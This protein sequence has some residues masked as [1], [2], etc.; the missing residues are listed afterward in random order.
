VANTWVN[1]IDYS[2]ST[3][4]K[5][6]IFGTSIRVDFRLVPLLKGL[7]IGE[8]VSQLIESHELSLNPEDPD[9]TR[10]TYKTT[11]TIVTDEYQLDEENQVQIIDEAA[12]G[13][14]FSRH[15]DLPRK[16]SYCVQ[17]TDVRGIRIKHR[18]KFRVQLHNPAGHVSEV[19]C[20]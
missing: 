6:I 17:D 19:S 1:K 15:L 14:T 13:Y 5:A 9:A 11:R 20:G 16:L 10:N 12:E 2:I 3:P 4:S 7:R 18:L 8:I